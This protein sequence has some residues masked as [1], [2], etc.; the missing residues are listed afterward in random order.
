MKN[1]LLTDDDILD[2]LMTSEF[3]EGLTQEEAKF[4]L[5]KYRYYYRLSHS[6]QNRLSEEIETLNKK[7]KEIES[8]LESANKDIQDLNLKLENEKNR[9]LTIKERLYGIKGTKK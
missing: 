4:L 6:K 9:K 5:L 3:N 8:N 7:I 1:T 2:Y